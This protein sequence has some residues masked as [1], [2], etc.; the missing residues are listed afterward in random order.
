MKEQITIYCKNNQKY[1]EF[2][3]GIS[4]MEIY[5]QID[6][7]TPYLLTCCRVDNKNE[8]LN[9]RC[10]RSKDIEYLDITDPSGLRTYVRT[11][12]FVL[13]KA[14]SDCFPN[15]RIYIEHPLSK[16]Y[17][18]DLEIG[19]GFQRLDDKPADVA[20]AYDGRSDIFHGS[21][22]L[23]RALSTDCAYSTSILNDPPS[24]RCSHTKVCSAPSFGTIVQTERTLRTAF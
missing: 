14:V 6:F 2:E 3:A 15:A 19:R 8:N 21:I 23:V 11:L 20:V 13:S 17:F 24:L 10:Y 12:C 5:E 16:G 9:F 4:V 1:Y 22:Y 18:C 7:K